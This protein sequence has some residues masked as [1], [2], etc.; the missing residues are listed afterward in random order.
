MNILLKIL[1]TIVVTMQQWHYNLFKQTYLQPSDF[2]LEFPAKV[3]QQLKGQGRSKSSVL[4]EDW[5]SFTTDIAI[6][7]AG[8]QGR[9]RHFESWWRK[10]LW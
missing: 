4:M 2:R 8:V 6:A 9:R 1:E 3:S 10:C 7:A 5:P